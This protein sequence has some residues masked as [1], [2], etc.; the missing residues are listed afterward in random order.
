MLTQSILFAIVSAVSSFT[1]YDPRDFVQSR[2]E[3]FSAV[4]PFANIKSDDLSFRV[5]QAIRIENPASIFHGE[6]VALIEVLTPKTHPASRVKL[7]RFYIYSL[8]NPEKYKPVSAIPQ[9]YDEDDKGGVKIMDIN[10]KGD[11]LGVALNGIPSY[12]TFENYQIPKPIICPHGFNCD[13]RTRPI[14]ILNDR[15]II[16]DQ[17]RSVSGMTKPIYFSHLWNPAR[18]E[19]TTSMGVEW[20]TRLDHKKFNPAI[21]R[22]ASRDGLIVGA[23]TDSATA[24]LPQGFF[25]RLSGPLNILDSGSLFKSDI[26]LFIVDENRVIAQ[27]STLRRGFR[28]KE[29]R[30]TVVATLLNLEFPQDRE[31]LPHSGLIESWSIDASGNAYVQIAREEPLVERF[32]FF[33]DSNFNDGKKLIDMLDSGIKEKII[34]TPTL[35]MSVKALDRGALLEFY[36]RWNYPWDPKRNHYYILVPR[37]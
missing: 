8:Q 21:V 17:Y 30:T 18:P 25:S 34:E 10:Q 20:K 16:T 13:K 9:L 15:T 12:W 7:K 31:P 2:V 28:P 27:S 5:V 26:P 36:P 35:A 4:V 1:S 19:L 3:D 33:E 22:D 29:E 6:D 14:K 37:E 11:L 32:E 23:L 24:K